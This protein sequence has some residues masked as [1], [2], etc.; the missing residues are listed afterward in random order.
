MSK[1]LKL[2]IGLSL[3]LLIFLI[4]IFFFLRFQ[5]IKSFPDYSGEKKSDKVKEEVKIYRDNF[6]VPTIYA[7]NEG[8][9]W[10][11]VGYIQAQDRLWQMDLYRRTMLG[12]LSEIF[13]RDALEYD[14]LFRTLDIKT[15]TKEIQK[16]LP[17]DV[18]NALVKYSE[19]VN[20]YIKENKGRYPV[21]FDILNY[22]PEIWEVEHS[23]LISRLMAWYL[24]FS[25]WTEIVRWK[26]QDKMGIQKTQE[27]FTEYPDNAPTIIKSSIPVS[28]VS[29]SLSSFLNLIRAHRE[30]I[31]F[32]GSGSGS[33]CWVVDGTKSSS[34]KP[35]LANDPHLTLPIPSHWYEMNISTDEFA[36]GGFCFPGTPFIIIG[37]N[38]RI[39]WGLTNAMIDEVDFFINH[40]DTNDTTKYVHNKK[41]MPIF[42]KEE[43][44]KIGKSDSVIFQVKKTHYGPVINSIHS[45]ICQADGFDSLLVSLKWV[46]FE[47]TL[48]TCTFYILNK[49][50]SKND[51]VDALKY[52]GVPGQNFIFADVEGNI[53]YRLA[54]KIPIRK[55]Y[56]PTLPVLASNIDCDWSGFISFE[57]LPELWNPAEH[58]IA[59]ANNKIVS[60]PNYYIT[61]LYMP[62]YRIERITQLLN[63]EPLFSV[64]DF[65]QMQMD[66]LSLHG[67]KYNKIILN[68]FLEEN[69]I[70][71]LATQALEYLKNWDYKNTQY[72]AAT[73]IFNM[74]FVKLL[75]NTFHDELGDEL[76]YEYVYFPAFPINTMD[77][78]I[79]SESN[80]FDNIETDTIETKRWIIKKSFLDAIQ[81]L[82]LKYGTE[83]KNWQWGN[84][85]Q[86][87]LKHPLGKIQ[88][89]N[90]VFNLGPYKLGGSSS[91]INNSEID[92][93]K[94][95]E[96][97]VGPSMRYIV[98]MYLP[99]RRYSVLAGGQSGH[100]L[101]QNYDD[102]VSLWLNGQYRE[103]YI[104]AGEN[105]NMKKLTIIPYRR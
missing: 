102:Q 64:E 92:F 104:A 22:E 28:K 71:P 45:S 96:A 73:S 90:S 10:F 50:K 60:H 69:S 4:A 78:L 87:T 100:A 89:L 97:L 19:G 1:P 66:L 88:P 98:D 11:A 61:N 23:L 37:H 52:F 47:P 43:I 93:T 81:E 105:A 20:A 8:D 67:Q 72:D 75:F 5:I 65:K 13:G 30:F 99:V 48:E 46:G 32:E 55:N 34:G 2:V 41:L 94:P 82:K 62:G 54:A 53:G 26:I 95:F 40:I 83:I 103:T 18:Q 42:T 59:S 12:R 7:K 86:L 68:I 36:T 25:W 79:E 24:N 76:Y 35:I 91:T 74:F 101:H 77:K 63:I 27:I 56:N 70:D 33:N 38:N 39:A 16:I 58:F 85:H 84:L 51:F 6:G 57:N 3:T 44:I 29:K 15:A 17:A 21:E 49:A 14:F 80:W 31:G 9:L